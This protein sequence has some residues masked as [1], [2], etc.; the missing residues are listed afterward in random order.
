[1][2]TPLSGVTGVIGATL[3]ALTPFEGPSDAQ[4]KLVTAPPSCKQA[5]AQSR[6][7]CVTGSHCQREISSILQACSQSSAASC[8]EARGD[9][10]TYC[11]EV[12][13]WYGTR[14]C[15]AALKQVR[16]YCDR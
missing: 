1:M 10:R 16:H 2:G 3:V 5:V 11:S 13:P 14:E 4:Y 15:D 8:V 12:S 7:L 9:L 6:M